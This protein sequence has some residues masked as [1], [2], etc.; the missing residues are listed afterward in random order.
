M[1]KKLELS[2]QMFSLGKTVTS[3]LLLMKLWI[4]KSY[5]TMVIIPTDLRLLH[6]LLI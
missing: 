5:P 4:M 3:V 2:Q 6:P 1:W